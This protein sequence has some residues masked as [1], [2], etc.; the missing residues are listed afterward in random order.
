MEL[1]VFPRGFLYDSR[2]VYFVESHRPSK[3]KLEE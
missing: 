1:L 2:N 3:V